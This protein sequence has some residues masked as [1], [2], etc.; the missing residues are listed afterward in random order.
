MFPLDVSAPPII[1]P[2]P[3]QVCTPSSSLPSPNPHPPSHS[4]R[5]RSQ[6]QRGGDAPPSLAFALALTT[7]TPRPLPSFPWSPAHVHVPALALTVVATTP[8][9]SPP[10]DCHGAVVTTAHSHCC[11]GFACIPSF[12]CL[13]SSSLWSPCTCPC[14]RPPSR[15]SLPRP[16]TLAMPTWW[17]QCHDN[18]SGTIAAAPSPPPTLTVVHTSPW[19]LPYPTPARTPPRSQ[20]R[21]GGNNNDITTHPHRRTHFTRTPPQPLSHP[22]LV[23]APSRGR[24]RSPSPSRTPRWPLPS[25]RFASCHPGMSTLPTLTLARDTHARPRTISGNY[26]IWSHPDFENGHMFFSFSSP[27][28]LDPISF[29]CR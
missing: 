4:P 25:P 20:H 23:H 3:Q 18:R 5:P 8:Q 17:R 1:I 21:C 29:V 6:P 13:P 24:H 15:S 10:R 19:S 11:A 26:Q 12:P 28:S 9:Q 22:A 14:A 2:T 27:S 7:R 16:L